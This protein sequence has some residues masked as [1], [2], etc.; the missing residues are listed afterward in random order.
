M[1]MAEVTQDTHTDAPTSEEAVKTRV[2]EILASYRGEKAELIPILQQVQQAYGYLPEAAL[3]QIAKF[4]DVPE[5][6]V[7]GVATFFHKE[8]SQIFIEVEYFARLKA[9]S[10]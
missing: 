8:M 9:I 5:C 2:N 10:E 7:F 1:T 3:S 6:T 4:V